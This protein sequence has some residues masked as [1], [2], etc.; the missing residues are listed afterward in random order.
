[1]A[2]MNAFY[3]QSGGVTAVINTT[4]CAVIETAKRYPETIGNLYVGRDSASIV[5]LAPHSK[6]LEHRA[7]KAIEYDNRAKAMRAYGRPGR[8]LHHF[9][10]QLIIKSMG[11]GVLVLKSYGGGKIWEKQ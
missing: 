9:K 5:I 8:F 10:S 7:V 2:K 3:A 4:A 11:S 6:A 1:M